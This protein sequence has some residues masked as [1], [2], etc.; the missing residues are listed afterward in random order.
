MSIFI[1]HDAAVLEIRTQADG[2]KEP[3]DAELSEAVEH[4]IKANKPT[5]VIYTNDQ[6]KTLSRIS[7]YFDWVEA[8][9]GIIKDQENKYLMIFRRGHWD[10]PKGKIDPGEL[11]YE[12]AVREIEEET[13]IRG[14][15]LQNSLP[16]SYH[17]YSFNQ[18]WVLKKTHWFLLWANSLQPLDLQKEEDIERAE[19]MSASKIR[20]ISDQ[21]Y[22]S[23]LPLLNAVIA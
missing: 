14:V 10:L 15:D 23:L 1:H 7:A 16:P 17:I 22:P 2:N 8:S 12:A 19:W 4:L 6:N 11:P 21:I 5:Q 13:G 18:K 9:G 20:A 3:S